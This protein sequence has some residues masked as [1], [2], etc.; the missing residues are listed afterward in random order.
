MP[1]HKSKSYNEQQRMDSM[2]DEAGTPNEEKMKK[3]PPSLNGI[4]K[5][6]AD[7]W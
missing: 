6:V 5:N 2:K 7:D 4:H 1:Q 3:R